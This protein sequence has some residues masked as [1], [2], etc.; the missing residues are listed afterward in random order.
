MDEFSLHGP[1]LLLAYS[2]FVLSIL[3]PGLNTVAIMGTSM[4]VGRSS[5]VAIALG[6]ATGSFCW[7]TLT[8]LG[9]SALLTR[10]A[11][12]LVVLKTAGGLYLLWLAFKALRAAA[13]PHDIEAVE[14]SAG[15]RSLTSFYLRG[16]TVQMTNPKAIF[17]WIAV[18]ALSLRPDPPLWVWF[19]VV[20]GG[21]TI[22][23][24]LHVVFAIA[25]STRSMIRAYT[26]GR[27]WIQGVL[28]VFFAFA[29][30]KMLTSRN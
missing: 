23:A 7:A 2:A 3:T 1:G 11:T 22:S 9:L 19:A 8:A 14:V 21:T 18:I 17:A 12:A 30:I 28:G 16:L 24:L 27:R 26:A 25:F 29:G 5:G 20:G 15:G 6:V 13:S 4:S 10:Y